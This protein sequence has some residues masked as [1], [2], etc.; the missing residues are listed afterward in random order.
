[1]PKDELD[2]EL[3]GVDDMDVDASEDI[4]SEEESE[5]EDSGAPEEEA[6]AVK[7][8][9]EKKS[10]AKKAKKEEESEEESESKAKEVIARPSSLVFGDLTVKEGPGLNTMKAR[11]MLRAFQSSP[12]V[13][14]VL[15]VDYLNPHVKDIEFQMQG[16]VFV[17]PLGEPLQVP[18]IVEQFIRQTVYGRKR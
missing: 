10:S 4:S 7:P 3:D 8:K 2:E 17:L 5:G 6:P 18:Q 11:N 13:P 9:K 14:T 1:M 16:V 12:L 15:P